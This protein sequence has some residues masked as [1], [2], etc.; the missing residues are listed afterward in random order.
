MVVKSKIFTKTLYLFLLCFFVSCKDRNV[1]MSILRNCLDMNEIYN[2]YI[3]Y[4]PLKFQMKNSNDTVW[5][6]VNG[7]WLYQHLSPSS[8]SYESF[9][10][11]VINSV[12]K[13]GFLT[14]DSTCFDLL[15]K[16]S[17]MRDVE[18]DSL[19]Q[20]EGIEGVLLNYVNPYGFLT[21]PTPQKLDYLIYLLYQHRIV[22]DS[23]SLG[24]TLE[25]NFYATDKCKEYEE[26]LN[27]SK[28]IASV[29]P[30]MKDDILDSLGTIPST[31]R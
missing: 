26:L 24:I 25:V 17:I 12:D 9:V 2:E 18:I 23:P 7:L 20:R 1:K 5:N 11:K 29:S 16:N 4:V 6:I 30:F 27:E 8:C 14:V 13:N 22:C 21:A 28:S 10:E 15:R 3:S 31:L 19:Y